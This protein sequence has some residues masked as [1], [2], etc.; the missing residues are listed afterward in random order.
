[1]TCKLGGQVFCNLAL[2]PGLP[3]SCYMNITHA[4]QNVPISHPLVVP[5]TPIPLT[6][7][8]LIHA[9][10]QLCARD[11]LLCWGYCT[12]VK[13]NFSFPSVF[14]FSQTLSRTI[15]KQFWALAVPTT[16]CIYEVCCWLSVRKVGIQC[17]TRLT[18]A[19]E[20]FFFFSFGAN[21]LLLRSFGC[22]W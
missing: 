20:I 6:D 7:I 3:A 2:S 14:L 21:N 22:P 12:K 4:T 5:P 13:S 17:K 16:K 19:W 18:C 11:A 8:K 10:I 9:C 15:Y 1:M